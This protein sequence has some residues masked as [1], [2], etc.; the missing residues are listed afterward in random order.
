MVSCYNPL[1]SESAIEGEAVSLDPGVFWRGSF[2]IQGSHLKGRTLM[3]TNMC[4]HI[5]VVKFMY[6]F[7]SFL[8]YNDGVEVSFLFSF[9]L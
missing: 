4:H 3:C 6:F 7:C 5:V 9:C 1:E 8:L 2:H